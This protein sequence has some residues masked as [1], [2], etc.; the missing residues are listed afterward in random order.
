MTEARITQLGGQGIVKTTPIARVTHVGAQAVT[1]NTRSALLTQMGVQAVVKNKATPGPRKAQLF[2]TASTTSPG[3]PGDPYYR[4][5]SLLLQGDKGFRDLSKYNDY[6]IGDR[7]YV[8]LSSTSP[9]FSRSFHCPSALHYGIRFYKNPERWA[10]NAKPFTIELWVNRPADSE[11]RSYVGSWS[12]FGNTRSW[13]LG[14]NANVLTFYAS[15]DGTNVAPGLFTLTGPTMPVNTWTHVCVDRDATGMVRMY[16]NGVMVA[17][18]SFPDAIYTTTKPLIALGY[19]H[20]SISTGSYIGFR[21]YAD[22][23]RI[24]K[25]VARYA[26]DS[27]FPLPAVPSPIGDVTY[28]SVDVD[29]YWDKVTC[30]IDPLSGSAID[31]KRGATVTGLTVSGTSL[32]GTGT[33]AHVDGQWDIGGRTE[34]FTLEI[35]FGWDSSGGNTLQQFICPGGWSISAGTSIITFRYW[36]GSAW[37]DVASWSNSVG[38][39]YYPHG[40]ETTIITR[41]ENGVFRCY[42]LGKLMATFQT[43]KFPAN[44]TADLTVNADSSR[45]VKCIRMTWGVA[46]YTNDDYIQDPIVDL[47]PPKSGPAYVAPT[48]P[49]PVYPLDLG[50]PDPET[51]TAKWAVSSGVVPT[52][53]S[54]PASRVVQSDDPTDRWRWAS[55]ASTY[56]RNYTELDIPVE[57][58]ADIDAGLVYLEFNGFGASNVY[59]PDAGALWAAA[60]DRYGTNLHRGMSNVVTDK[61]MQ[62]MEG[63]I[64]LPAGT[65]RVAVGFLSYR[66]GT[67]G[68]FIFRKVEARLTTSVPQSRVYLEKPTNTVSGALASNTSEWVDARGGTV[69]NTASLNWNM[70]SPATA[71]R[72]MDIRCTETLPASLITQIDAGQAAFKFSTLVNLSDTN[73]LGRIYVEFLDA[74]DQVVGQRKYNNP[75][76]Y[77]PPPLSRPEIYAPIP[78]TARKVVMGIIGAMDYVELVN[79]TNLASFFTGLH[80][81]YCYIPTPGNMPAAAPTPP[82]LTSDEYWDD[83]VFLLT[84]RN[85][86][87]ENL[88]QRDMRRLS[89]AGSVAVSSIN[90]PFGTTAISSNLTVTAANTDYIEAELYGPDFGPKMTFE[91]WF[92]KTGHTARTWA[93]IHN[94]LSLG[95]DS[96]ATPM[97]L[98][99][100]ASPFA[101]ADYQF[102]FNEWYH[103]ALC[104]DETGR[105]NLFINGKL[106]GRVA[107]ASTALWNRL[108]RLFYCNNAT[109][110]ASW[111]GYV[112]EIRIT[113]G[114]ERY[115]T[116]FTPPASRF[117]TT[118]PP[119]PLLLT[120]EAGRLMLTGDTGAILLNGD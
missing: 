64:K 47:Q 37:V 102:V 19:A 44:P 25:D 26:S 61:T 28:E 116:N 39:W 93:C 49:A 79:G 33:I 100:S 17:S 98:M 96:A 45:S 83:V 108:F 71:G 112:D 77:I 8:F 38:D 1:E 32:T 35:D 107:G 31:H 80:E 78:P 90:S 110:Q 82:I 69:I 56:V 99:G 84:T 46:R 104:R 66:S 119:R 58:A 9:K 13:V 51:T 67:A 101:Q 73:D 74:A 60:F 52:V 5:V 68:D 3:I 30:L 36:N 34:P 91:G 18:A 20:F 23:L 88:A 94:Q 2:Q 62:P 24:T 65:R 105:G 86:V 59:Q 41:D 63:M 70:T 27:G 115:T 4:K 22:D 95:L 7:G 92:M 40:S 12:I 120:G 106:Q 117:P 85:G 109:D 10:F 76:A 113:N 57:Y 114:V 14:A 29:P 89:I 21:G 87:I 50:F 97:R 75:V 81:A 103:L 15:R 42:Q 72:V 48:L 11:W 43:N 16:V 54:V 55:G 53:V 118:N 111:V 6:G